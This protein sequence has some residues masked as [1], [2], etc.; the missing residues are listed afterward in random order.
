MDAGAGLRPAL[1]RAPRRAGAPVRALGRAGAA[2][3][4]APG[5]S[6]AARTTGPAAGEGPGAD[7]GADRGARRGR[8]RF[9]VSPTDSLRRCGVS[10]SQAGA[11]AAV[12]AVM[13]AGAEAGACAAAVADVG[14]DRGARRGR[15]RFGV[16]PTDS[17]RRCGV[18]TS[19]A[20]AG[21]AV[22]AVTAA[23]AAAGAWPPGAGATGPAGAPAACRLRPSSPWPKARPVTGAAGWNRGGGA[24]ATGRGVAAGDAAAGACRV[25]RL[26]R[27]TGSP[28]SA[29][30]RPRVGRG[31]GIQRPRREL[32]PAGP[33]QSARPGRPR[34]LVGGLAPRSVG[35]LWT[36]GPILLSPA[37]PP[38][39]A[40][41]TATAAG[42]R[43]RRARS[44]RPRTRDG[45][46]Q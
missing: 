43:R 4:G 39:S 40:G 19:Q 42:R 30:G 38:G 10:T 11:G 44:R 26:P 5:A 24:A 13:A 41:T 15:E 37:S 18:S 29:D 2:L 12:G 36:S 20:G 17:L 6:S 16:S 25:F 9:G 32:E 8:E 35:G 21:A 22:G 46:R 34:K 31:T 27:P 3:D 23:G 1:A 28:S 33:D 7:V 14:A 45:P